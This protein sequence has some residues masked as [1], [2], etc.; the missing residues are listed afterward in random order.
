MQRFDKEERCSIKEVGLRNPSEVLSTNYILKTEQD[1]SAVKLSKYYSSSL[2]LLFNLITF[3]VS[4]FSISWW[5]LKYPKGEWSKWFCTLI[6]LTYTELVLDLFISLY[7]CKTKKKL[8]IASILVLSI[9][10][11]SISPFLPNP[12]NFFM[13]VSGLL[14]SFSILLTNIFLNISQKSKQK[15][16]ENFAQKINILNIL[17]ED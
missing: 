4:A 5:V 15:T 14:L 16:E 1:Q 7:L 8:V 3:L 17:Q 9:L 2:S 10:L 13:M 6:V 12:Q 11:T